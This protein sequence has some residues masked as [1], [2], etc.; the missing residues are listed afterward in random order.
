M[1]PVANL[2]EKNKTNE[3]QHKAGQGRPESKNSID[4][5][6]RLNLKKN[7]DL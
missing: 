1:R 7:L 4:R 3:E 5:L 2:N 6:V